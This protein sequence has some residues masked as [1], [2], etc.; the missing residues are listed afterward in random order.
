MNVLCLDVGCDR[1]VMASN[2]VRRLSF[3]TC[4]HPSLSVALILLTPVAVAE[5]QSKGP[6]LIMSG[7]FRCNIVFLLSLY[8]LLFKLDTSLNFPPSTRL[9]NIF[10]VSGCP[11]LVPMG[12]YK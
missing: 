11:L 9:N 10:M 4:Q 8:Y 1:E 7:P 12:V 5:M 6:Y 3:I 2:L